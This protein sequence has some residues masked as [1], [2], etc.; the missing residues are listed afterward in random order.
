MSSFPLRSRLTKG[1]GAVV[2]KTAPGRWSSKMVEQKLQIRVTRAEH[3]GESR[4]LFFAPPTFARFLEMPMVAHF[5]QGAFAIDFFLQSSQRPIYRLALLK[6][7]L[8]QLTSLPLGDK[9]RS[10][11]TTTGSP[12]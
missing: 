12:A 9:N 1:P 4:G 10:R 5:F 11:L 3:G 2:L 6:P 7:N 8:G